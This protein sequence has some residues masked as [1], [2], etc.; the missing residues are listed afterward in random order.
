[1][2][3]I[4]NIV[5]LDEVAKVI[6]MPLSD[7]SKELLRKTA[8]ECVYLDNTKTDAVIKSNVELLE[9]DSKA[10]SF[11]IITND[12]CSAYYL[13]YIL[14]TIPDNRT[15]NKARETRSLSSI[16]LN[17]QPVPMVPTEIQRYIIRL[18]ELSEELKRLA[19][20]DVYADLGGMCLKEIS[21][22]I[23][24]ELFLNE[25]CKDNKISIIDGWIEL[26]QNIPLDEQRYIVPRILLRTGNLLMTE[27]R[28]L[29]RILVHT[30]NDMKNGSQN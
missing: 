13:K 4:P 25:I 23:N 3:E 2:I 24:S 26:I 29:Q 5:R 16:V 27:V 10:K 14:N 11:A 17:G 6:P 7:G 1:M 15:I 28:T 19:Q 18:D 8:A 12:G 20:I 21:I 30:H 9:I 22:G